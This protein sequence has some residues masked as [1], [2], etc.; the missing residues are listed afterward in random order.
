MIRC[1]SQSDEHTGHLILHST[2]PF[3]THFCLLPLCSSLLLLHSPS[4]VYIVPL[5]LQHPEPSGLHLCLL[6]SPSILQFLSSPSVSMTDQVCFLCLS[7][8]CLPVSFVSLHILIIAFSFFFAI[9]FD[10]V[11]N[12]VIFL[13]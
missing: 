13:K 3:Y 7:P 1:R 8:L 9:P 2:S 5:A 6:Q 11:L 4:S 10:K 12:Q